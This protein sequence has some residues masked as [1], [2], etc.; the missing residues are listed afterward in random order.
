MRSHVRG[1][2]N[3]VVE[4][5]EYVIESSDERI[6]EPSK[7]SGAVAHAEGHSFEAKAAVWRDEARLVAVLFGR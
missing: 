5:N 1:E 6:H 3:N 2:N 7:R 4:I